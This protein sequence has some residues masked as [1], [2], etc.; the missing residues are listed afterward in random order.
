M[1]QASAELARCGLQVYLY[2]D[3][4]KTVNGQRSV[5]QVKVVLCIENRYSFCFWRG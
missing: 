2:G 5:Y 1:Q 4:C 3:V